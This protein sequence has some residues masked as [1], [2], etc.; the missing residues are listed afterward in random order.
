MLVNDSQNK[1]TPALWYVFTPLLAIIALIL[2]VRQTS[3]TAPHRRDKR[4]FQVAAVEPTHAAAASIST[5][6]EDSPGQAARGEAPSPGGTAARPE[7]SLSPRAPSLSPLS[8]VKYTNYHVS[9]VPWSIHVA[10]VDRQSPQYEIQSV[11]A[12]GGAL[13]VSTLSA[14]VA[15]LRSTKGVPVAAVNGD[16]FHRNGTYLG[17][18]RGLQVVKGEVISAP[19]GGTSFWIDSAGQPH[20]D[21]VVSRFSVVWPNN[22][23]TPCGLNEERNANG[24]VLYTPAIGRSTHTWGG[25]ELVLEKQGNSPWLPLR[26]AETYTARVR[27]TREA[28]DTLLGPDSLVLSLGPSAARGL[29]RIASGATLKIITGTV[30]SLPD[31]KSAIGGGPVLVRH[32]KRQE[33]QPTSLYSYES[34][35][36]FD[37]HPRTAIGWNARSFFL[38]EV[39]GRQWHL[40]VGMT[41][42]ELAGF[43]IKLG[44]EEAMNFDGGGSATFWFNGKV[45]N[46]PCDGHER[47]IANSL[48]VVSKASQDE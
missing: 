33:I 28:G 12:R 6:A 39:D 45:Q 5:R 14:H 20:T 47:A 21:T 43:M 22:A 23:M 35:S 10:Q 46:S 38:V 37:R 24:V 18:P 11:H 30:P 44:C 8:G 26:M 32:G 48:V 15:L 17:D 31:V 40:S 19:R 25:R 27:E 29:P 4:P 42:E 2:V 16:Y 7:D 34:I 13:G 3:R 9:N 1:L 41:L 36:M